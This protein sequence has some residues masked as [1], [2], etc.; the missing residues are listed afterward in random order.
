MRNGFNEF[1]KRRVN[2]EITQLPE[3][4][5]AIRNTIFQNPLPPVQPS[6]QMVTST[7]SSIRPMPSFQHSST[8]NILPNFSSSSGIFSPAQLAAMRPTKA[9]SE[10]N[11]VRV[12]IWTSK[13]EDGQHTY[14]ASAILGGGNIGHAT[15]ETKNVYASIWPETGASSPKQVVDPEYVSDPRVDTRRESRD[16]DYVFTFYSLDAKNIEDTFRQI[17]E[18]R[19]PWTLLGNSLNDKG[20]SCS[21]LT[22]SLLE[23]G[24]LNNLAGQT[25]RGALSPTSNFVA[26]PNNLVNQLSYASKVEQIK[27]PEIMDF[28]DKRSETSTQK[29]SLL[30]TI[31]AGKFNLINGKDQQ[32]EVSSDYSATPTLKPGG[33]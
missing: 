30:V 17:Q 28:H 4:T 23:K 19:E 22:L 27:N 10:D 7:V 26:S 5:T 18:A 33:R 13:T 11:W 3:T 9:L 15:L 31:K 14:A 24:G 8:T 6:N 12:R 25:I 2:A 29:E 20:Y 1:V 16:P 32:N 21:S